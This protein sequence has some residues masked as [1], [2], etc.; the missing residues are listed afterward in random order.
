MYVFMRHLE[1]LEAQRIA[2][3]L[4]NE[5]VVA[6]PMHDVTAMGYNVRPMSRVVL[7]DA[8]EKEVAEKLVKELEAEPVEGIEDDSEAAPDLSLLD[9]GM[10]V[11][12]PS[13]STAI[14]ANTGDSNCPSCRTPVDIAELVAEQFGPEAL[15]TCYPQEEQLAVDESTGVPCTKCGYWLGGLPTTGNCPECSIAYDKSQI[16]ATFLRNLTQGRYLGEPGPDERGA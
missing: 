14:T 7:L 2:S 15:D 1:P 9:P 10:K 4:L 8:R 5:G 13:C 16:V 6:A 3:F 11:E 12:C